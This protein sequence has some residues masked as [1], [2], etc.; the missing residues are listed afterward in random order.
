M[1]DSDP[2][3][4]TPIAGRI[5]VVEPNTQSIARALQALTVAGYVV[6]DEMTKATDSMHDLS[7]ALKELTINDQTLPPHLDYPVVKRK[8]QWKTETR[9][10]TRK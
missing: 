3:G 7:K 6:I 1:T 9:G 10:R 4:S 2:S 5:I 8:A